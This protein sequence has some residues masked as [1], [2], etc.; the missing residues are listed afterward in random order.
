MNPD[1]LQFLKD[2]N[3][4]NDYEVKKTGKMLTIPTQINIIQT[5]DFKNDPKQI[6]PDI[7]NRI[8]WMDIEES[9]KIILSTYDEIWNVKVNTPLRYSSIPIIKSRIKITYRELDKKLD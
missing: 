6:I 7:K 3:A 2:S 4:T 5:Y 9:K 1:T 8:A